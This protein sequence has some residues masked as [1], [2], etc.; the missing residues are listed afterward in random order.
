MVRT[1]LM[2]DQQRLTP[3]ILGQHCY[4]S[5]TISS[6]VVT[7]INYPAWRAIRVDNK[8][9]V[10]SGVSVADNSF[11][12]NFSNNS[13]NAALGYDAAGSNDWTV[14]NL[15]V[16][17]G[18]SNDSVVDTPT[19]YGDDTGAGGEVRGNYATWSVIDRSTNVTLNNGNLL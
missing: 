3:R 1:L 16:A 10:N 17:A 4:C 12:L 14:N 19:N 18:V 7:G 8:I 2:A 6:I 13:S 5:G 9:L 15:S 11:K